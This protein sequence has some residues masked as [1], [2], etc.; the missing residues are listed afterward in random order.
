MGGDLEAAGL[1]ASLA[2]PG[3][4]VTGISGSTAELAEKS[5]ELIT[6]ILPVV[7]QVAV[8]VNAD[9]LFGEALLE[10]VETAAQ[11]RGIKAKAFRVHESRELES[12]FESF[13]EW[14]PDALLVHPAL[15]QKLIADLALQHRLPAIC[16]SSAF[17]EVGGLA[18]YAADIETL[19]RQ[20]AIFGDKILSG[21]R[22][23][24]L[25]V[26][27]PTRFRLIL[28]L[29]TAKA[30]GLNLPPVLLARADEVIE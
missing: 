30:I 28:N 22:P 1:V 24:D 9:S 13:V 19:A 7:R 15:P 17:C 29:K 23:S 25:P 4:N 10:H 26:E 11:A 5:L 21:R 27:L 6:E 8:L 16:P 20:C 3:G 2:R 14:K 18:S 12:D